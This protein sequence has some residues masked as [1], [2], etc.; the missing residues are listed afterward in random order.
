MQL[1]FPPNSTWFGDGHAIEPLT[2]Q[3]RIQKSIDGVPWPGSAQH[4]LRDTTIA[5]ER[6]SV[7]LA[8]QKH[9]HPRQ[10]C[11]MPSLPE[12][13]G[14]WTG[15]KDGPKTQQT[16]PEPMSI[17]LQFTRRFSMAHRL[18]SGRSD[19]C[20]TPHGHNE[21]VTVVLEPTHKAPLDGEANMVVE[22][23]RAKTRWHAFV[24]GSLDHALQL[25]AADPLLAF[26]NEHYPSWRIVVT[27]GD[28]TT[29]LMAALLSS[30][31]QAI[32]EDEGLGL[33]VQRVLL[34]ETPT[35]TVSV[36]GDARSWLP[37]GGGWWTRPDASTR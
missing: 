18:I 13:E 2:P 20:A 1:V 37:E 14:R 21:F 5:H 16:G 34:E 10:T 23:S 22:F 28:P 9:R 30:K 27:P 12:W 32:L 3:N 19:L 6:P 31:C 11:Y 36:E 24:D 26:A 33:K 17:C 25:A 4:G 15:A 29:E 8:A 7:L 35:N